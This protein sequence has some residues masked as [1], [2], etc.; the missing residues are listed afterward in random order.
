MR[1]RVPAVFQRGSRGAENRSAPWPY[2][3]RDLVDMEYVGLQLGLEFSSRTDAMNAVLRAPV[4]RAVSM[5]PLIEPAWMLGRAAKSTDEWL[6]ALKRPGSVTELGPMFSLARAGARNDEKPLDVLRRFLATADDAT[7]LFVT[8]SVGPVTWGDYRGSVMVLCR[9]RAKRAALNQRRGRATWDMEEEQAFRAGLELVSPTDELRSPLVSVVMPVYNRSAIVGEAIESVLQQTY[10]VWELVIVDDGSTDDTREVIG[11]YAERDPRVRLVTQSKSGVSAA[12]NRGIAE[13]RGGLIA[14]LD[15]D[16]QWLEDYLHI[17][18]SA[19]EQQPVQLTWTGVRRREANGEVSYIGMQGGRDELLHGMSFIDMNVLVVRKSA[20]ERAGGFDQ[21]IR[22]WVDFDLVLRLLAA[23]DGLYV[24]IVGVE[25]EHSAETAG[26]ITTTE[27]ETW[28][29]VV[30]AKYLVDWERVDRGMRDRVSGRVSAVIWRRNDWQAVARSVRSVLREADDHGLDVEVVIVDNAS[31][32]DFEAVLSAVFAEDGRVKIIPQ[33][34]DRA[35]ANLAN[36]GFAASTGES[37]LMLSGAAEGVPGWLP[38][39]VNSLSENQAVHPLV[40]AADGTVG[41]SGY[42]FAGNRVRPRALLRGH[43]AED[44]DRAEKVRYRAISASAM[45]VRATDFAR[46]RG[47]RAHFGRELFDVDF[48]LRLG[49][50]AE[51]FKLVRDAVMIDSAIVDDGLM[52][53]DEASA[54]AFAEL[55]G[56]HDLGDD[57][58]PALESAGFRRIGWALENQAGAVPGERRQVS[59]PRLRGAIPVLERIDHTRR[60]WAIKIS[61]PA[62]VRGRAWGDTFFAGDLKRA[63]ESFGEQVV[64]DPIDA[65]FRRT[66]YLDDVVLTIRG[67]GKVPP[68]PGALNLLWVISHPDLVSIDEVKSYD[69]VYAASASWAAEMTARS[70]RLVQPLLQATNPTRFRPATPAPAPGPELLFVGTPRKAMRPIVQHALD[71]GFRPTIYGHGWNGYVAPELV[72]GDHVGAAELGSLYQ[73]ARV[74]LNDHWADMRRRG[75]ISNRVFDVVAAGGRVVSDYVEGINELFGGVVRTYRD[76]DELR[77]LLRP[78]AL[79][80]DEEI[81]KWS[82]RVRELHSFEARARTL[83]S[84]VARYTDQVAHRNPR[85]TD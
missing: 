25:Y 84:D 10:Q 27:R 37:V 2:N 29:D 28:R 56:E 62:E 35:D 75:F 14:F 82:R 50:G 32:R 13:A 43:P 71:A 9:E 53:G 72:A 54:S 34:I 49:Q 16:N 70:G 60:R 76:P 18:V 36:I 67:L 39:L 63:L 1:L 6:N 40:L 77:D 79:P 12:R 8:E 41:Q 48:C 20:I 85:A 19:L 61:T 69:L 3:I 64:V 73:S 81:R 4:S 26:R 30:L 55:W 7:E 83:L 74:V 46:L 45:L 22:R 47:F 23:G 78:E 24:P 31:A 17:S 51:T 66:R 5:H 15:S 80:P 65:H 68:Q 59:F 21:Q 44:F 38:R 11:K 58:L 52:P 57:S 33:A 42:V